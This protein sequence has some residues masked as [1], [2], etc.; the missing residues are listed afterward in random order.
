MTDTQ[1]LIASLLMGTLASFAYKQALPHL[2]VPSAWDTRTKLIVGAIIF[3]TT[4]AAGFVVSNAIGGASEAALTTA[5]DTGLNQ[6]DQFNSMD[7]T[8][9]A[10]EGR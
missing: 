7:A 3:L 6:Q 5:R 10:V 1:I 8:L 9:N 4:S 2:T